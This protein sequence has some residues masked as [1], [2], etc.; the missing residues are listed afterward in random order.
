MFNGKN[1]D[2]NEWIS[3]IEKLSNLTGKPEYV[4]PLAKSSG[5]P[6][7]MISQTPSNTAWSKLKKE[8]ARSL[9]FSGNRHACS[10]RSVKKTAC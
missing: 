8:S 3:Q 2:F 9:F 7:K 6:Y 4:L 10:H 1:I 5:T